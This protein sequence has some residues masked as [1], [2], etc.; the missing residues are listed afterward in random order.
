MNPTPPA[1][2]VWFFN[3]NLRTTSPL[4]NPTPPASAV[5]F[6]NFSTRLKLNLHTA[7]AGGILQTVK[8]SI[9]LKLKLHA[10]KADG[11]AFMERSR[12]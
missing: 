11:I 3:F 2:A 6:F 12:S 7:E 8:R 1:L 4:M 5:W 9:R 10:A